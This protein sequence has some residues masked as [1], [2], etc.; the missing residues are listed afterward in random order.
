MWDFIAKRAKM[1]AAIAAPGV[2]AV[3]IKTIEAVTGF[4]IPTEWETSI[5]GL[6]TSFVGASTVYGIA[7]RQPDGLR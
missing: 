5:L 7:N 6:I 4:D 2:A 1:F 3:L